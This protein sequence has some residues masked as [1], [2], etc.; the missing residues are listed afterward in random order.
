MDIIK[1]LCDE[2]KLQEWQIKNTVELIDDGKTIPFISRYRKEKTGS[3]DDQLIRSIFER[4]QYIRNLE[5]RK[6][7]VASAIE[8]QEKMTPEITV[9][10]EKAETLVEV[11]DIYRP[12]KQKRKTRA[13]V[14]KEKGLE[15]LAEKILEQDYSYKPEKEAESFIDN[16]KDV[17]T[18]DDAL[19]GAMD[20]IA[21]KVSDDSELRRRI[22]NIF[23]NYSFISSKAV[24]ENSSSVYENYYD[25]KESVSK[26]AGH[27]VLAI[28][29]GEKEKILKVSVDIDEGKGES[30]CE[31]AYVKNNSES[32]EF[33]KRACNDGY[34]RLIYPSI[35]REVRAALTENAAEG[36]IKVFKENLRQ[37]L[38]QPPIKNTVTLGFDPGFRTGCKIAVVDE[39]G[40]VLETGVVHPTMNNQNQ[41][42]ESERKIK[43]LISKY[44]ISTIAI[45][46]G[47]A[48]RESEEFISKI[49]K[50]IDKKVSYMV[51]SEAG[52]SVYSASKLGAEEFPDFDVSVR[53]AVSI[54]RRLQDPLAELVKINPEAIGVGQYQ[55][56]M[57][58]ARMSEALGGV[59]EDCVNH[60]GADLNTASYSLLS[61][62]AGINSTIAKNIVAYREEN[63]AFISR[64]QLLKV[65]RLGPKAFEQ[66]AGFLRIRDGK[67]PLDNTSVHPESYDTARKLI[68]KYDIPLGDK[69][70]MQDLDKYVEKDGIDKVAEELETGIPTLKDIIKALQKPGLDPRD[71][72]PPPIMRSGDVMEIKD[73]KTGMEL[74][75]TVRNVIDFGAFVDIGVHQDGL[76]HISQI[77]KKFIK[78]PLDAVKVGQIVKVWVLGVDEKKGRISLTMIKPE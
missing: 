50:D 9:A 22:R 49:V 34:T 26:I 31:K 73:L 62:V 37:L 52:A 2:F 47:T 63:G 7:E 6:Q 44:N 77:S 46:N 16:E 29:R 36:A 40:K 59:V 42:K 65:P 4:L 17:E 72:L 1:K 41:I 12:F 76:V 51:V 45:G 58:K 38:L 20:I 78:H 13:S 48:S 53:S 19:N 15:P 57:P 74:V 23:M 30:I 24:D 5:E 54:A 32:S 11:E 39:T 61:Y 21:E 28:D 18:I 75:G 71:E 3:L 64:K 8:S 55:H 70:K 33:V 27:R 10:L 56:D 43:E 25:F 66:C 69:E 67:E 35:E 60:V 14:A 68:A